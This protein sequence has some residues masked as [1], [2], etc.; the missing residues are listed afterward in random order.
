LT[1]PAMPA[2]K[3]LAIIFF[4]D[5]LPVNFIMLIRKQVGLTDLLSITA[6]AEII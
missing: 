3:M 5:V 4:M 6:L 2:K 1:L